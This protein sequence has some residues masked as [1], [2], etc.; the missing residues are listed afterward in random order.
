MASDEDTNRTGVPVFL[1][2]FMGAG[3]TTV[4]QALAKRLNCE[5]VDVDRQIEARV[6]KSISDIFAAMGET[7]FRRLESEAI[8]ECRGR[9]RTVIALGGG[10]YTSEENRN[11][12]RSIGET[13]WLDCPFEICV[14][15]VIGDQSRPLVT[16]EAQ[17]RELFELR[18]PAYSQADHVVETGNLSPDQLAFEIA[19]IVGA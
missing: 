12:L 5:F 13:V 10:A 4:G 7:K 11:V 1:I 16:D 17:M 8:D 3:K 2:G 14:Q 18:R 19:R 6:G 15:R 9:E